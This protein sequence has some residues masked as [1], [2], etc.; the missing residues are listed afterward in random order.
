MNK[1]EI[2][3]IE[4]NKVNIEN[5]KE[6]ICEIKVQVSNHIP[7][8]LRGLDKRIDSIAIKLAGVVAVVS[9]LT[10]VAFRLIQ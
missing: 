2:I 10:Q 5:I 4:A 7:T 9:I 8:Q 3:Q 1:E 6:D